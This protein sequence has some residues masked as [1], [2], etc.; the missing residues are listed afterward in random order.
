ML[1]TDTAEIISHILRLPIINMKALPYISIVIVSLNNE[2]SLEEC[3]R[4]VKDQD[5]PRNKI[6]Y[7]AIDGGSSDQTVALFKKFDFRVEASP[8]PKNAEAQRAIGLKLASYNLIVS[9]DADNYLP[10]RLWLRQMV[11]PFMDDPTVIHAGTMYYGYR[12]TDSLYNR[13][14]G[15]FGNVDPIVYYI[16]RPDRLPRY[17]KSWTSGKIIADRQAYTVVEFDTDTLPTVGCNGVVYRR[18]ILLKYAKST[19]KDFLHIDVF[20]DAIKSGHRRFAIVKNDVIHDTA[21]S[22]FAL[23]KKR[24]AF[25]SHYYLASEANRRY[26]IYDPHSTKSNIK[27]LLYIFYTVT[28][29]KPSIDAFRGYLVIQDIAWFMHPLVCW[30]YLFSY[31]RAIIKRTIRL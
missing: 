31:G 30:I 4:R 14:V 26:L 18:D 6:E 10:T 29:V 13:Y 23:I 9:I 11:Q 15:L 3:L 28:L 5:Y 21:V 2:R 20:A 17:Q 16:G 24:I 12:K 27:L 25:L 22:L 8:I 19:P 1:H 7:L